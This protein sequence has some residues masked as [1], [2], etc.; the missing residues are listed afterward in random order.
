M[1]ITVTAG[2]A[3]Q[4]R[5]AA[6]QGEAEDMALRIAARRSDDGSV[7]FGMG[8]D[9]LRDKDLEVLSEGVT[10]LV[11]PPSVELVDGVTL[12]FVE[13]EPGEFRFVFIAPQAP[14]PAP[15]E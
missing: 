3:E 15:E 8:F 10:L 9:R 1:R 14:E 7:E 4:I 6:A 2:A 5:T 12:D 11:A 13:V